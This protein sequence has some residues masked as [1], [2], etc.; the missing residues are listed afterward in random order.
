MGAARRRLASLKVAPMSVAPLERA[1]RENV[2][3][4][5]SA[6]VAYA[7]GVDSAVVLAIAVQELGARALAITGIS[8]SMA[9]G[10]AEAA[11][12]A[13]RAMGARHETIA[14]GEVDERRHPAHTVHRS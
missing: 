8:P 3:S 14:T 7:G 9:I 12:T 10:E 4:L 1:L 5:G 2:R 11:A 13:A 6:V